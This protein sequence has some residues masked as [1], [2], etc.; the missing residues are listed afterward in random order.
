MDNF[1]DVNI[2]SSKSFNHIT[3]KPSCYFFLDSFG[4]DHNPD[5]NEKYTILVEK[6]FVMYGTII[7]K[8]FDMD[9]MSHQQCKIKKKLLALWDIDEF[10]Q[11]KLIN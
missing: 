6:D 11:L 1:I 3:I 7:N 9:E 8:Y 2:K 10:V 4:T 5:Y